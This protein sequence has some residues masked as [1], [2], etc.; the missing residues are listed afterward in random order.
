MLKLHSLYKCYGSECTA[1]KDQQVLPVLEEFTGFPHPKVFCLLLLTCQINGS[2]WAS[3]ESPGNWVPF[4][5]SSF[6]W[7]QLEE[8]SWP[9][10]CHFKHIGTPFLQTSTSDHFPGTIHATSSAKHWCGSLLMLLFN[11]LK[12]LTERTILAPRRI[13]CVC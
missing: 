11:A 5:T 10:L 6:L 2:L 13:F 4:Q 1:G 3:V 12:N 9:H 7:L 8:L